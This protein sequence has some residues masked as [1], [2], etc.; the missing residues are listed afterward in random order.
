MGSISRATDRLPRWAQL[1]LMVC[2]LAVG[3][4]GFAHY[5]WAFLFKAIF[6][7]EP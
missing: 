5:G 4:Y 1:I 6:S 7:P 2:G 3:V